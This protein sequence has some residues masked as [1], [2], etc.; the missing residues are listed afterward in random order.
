MAEPQGSSAGGILNA[1]ASTAS[2][3]APDGMGA[4]E[5]PVASWTAEEEGGM[6]ET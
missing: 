3:D 6:I 4:G 5:E 1:T 2:A